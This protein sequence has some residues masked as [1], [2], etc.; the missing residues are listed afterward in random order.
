MSTENDGLD[1]LR[2]KLNDLFKRMS[3][4]TPVYKTLGEIAVGSIQENFL[5]GG[6]FGAG[7]FGGGTT[8][9]PQ[10]IRV[11]MFGGKT[12]IDKGHL[13]SSISYVADADGVTL[14]AGPHPGAAQLNFGGV[15]KAKNVPFLRFTPG[16]TDPSGN[17]RG[18]WVRKRSVTQL[19]RPYMVLQDEDI[20]DMVEAVGIF[21]SNIIEGG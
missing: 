5:V 3:D 10:S 17:P 4:L 11:S 18:P 15:I 7:P 13:S 20:D 9:W 14:T 19:A 8:K 12:M 6:R 21:A 1:E 2:A 16:G